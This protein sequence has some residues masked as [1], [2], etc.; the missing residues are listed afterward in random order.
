MLGP[1]EPTPVT[2]TTENIKVKPLPT[3]HVSSEE[4]MHLE[5]E[6]GAHK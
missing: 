1:T 3:E 6:Y 2:N 5:H 4:V